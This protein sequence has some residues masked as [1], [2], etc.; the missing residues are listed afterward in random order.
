MS[1]E[2]GSFQTLGDLLR[3][4]EREVIYTVGGGTLRKNEIDCVLSTIVKMG[5]SFMNITTGRE[6]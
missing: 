4:V 6:L 1:T 2:H 5:G 3:E